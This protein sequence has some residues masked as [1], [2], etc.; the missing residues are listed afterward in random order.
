MGTSVSR[1]TLDV[2]GA[3]WWPNEPLCTALCWLRRAG[4]CGNWAGPSEVIRQPAPSWD[5]TNWALEIEG[6]QLVSGRWRHRGPIFVCAEVE[7]WT[8]LCKRQVEEWTSHWFLWCSFCFA[9]HLDPGLFLT[10][11][12]PLR[13]KAD[14][15]PTSLQCRDGGYIP[16]MPPLS[17][18]A[19]WHWHG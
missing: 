17:R 2:H 16:R 4:A 7:T 14:F 10:K 8:M 15:F 13:V 3:T 11:D 6:T 1:G 9:F 19:E 5:M 12:E 18:V